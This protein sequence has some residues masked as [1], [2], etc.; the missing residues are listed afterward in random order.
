MDDY[1]T[2]ILFRNNPNTN[3]NPYPNPNPIIGFRN[4]EPSEQRATPKHAKWA[5]VL[6]VE[7]VQAYTHSTVNKTIQ[8]HF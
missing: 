3:P 5:I 8:L 6:S 2:Y 1:V 7:L 4:N